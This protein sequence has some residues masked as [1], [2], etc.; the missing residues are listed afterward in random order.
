MGRNKDDV[1]TATNERLNNFIF[2]SDLLR[3][4]RE[5]EE[6]RK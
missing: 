1:F 3:K 5:V 2:A 6:H 4:V